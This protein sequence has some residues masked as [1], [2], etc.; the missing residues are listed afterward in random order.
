MVARA[1]VDI[2]RT[3]RGRAE[4]T[5]VEKKT[6]ISFAMEMAM[7]RAKGNLGTTMTFPTSDQLFIMLI[8]TESFH[9]HHKRLPGVISDRPATMLGETPTE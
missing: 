4:I 1:E 2:N 8:A 5:L 6:P 3:S 7:T 9:E